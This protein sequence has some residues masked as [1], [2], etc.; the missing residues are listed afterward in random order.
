MSGGYVSVE[1]LQA[2]R[3]RERGDPQPLTEAGILSFGQLVLQEHGEAFLEAQGA[4]V[5]IAELALEGAEHA[6]EF[7]FIEQ[8][9]QGFD[10]HRRFSYG[11]WLLEVIGAAHVRMISEP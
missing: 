1:I 4:G 2:R 10:Q 11:G 9:Q 5:G 3:L 6:G 8:L 7:E